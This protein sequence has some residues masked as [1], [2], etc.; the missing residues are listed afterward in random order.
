MRA[1]SSGRSKGAGDWNFTQRAAY[2][3]KWA[4][5]AQHLFLGFDSDVDAQRRLSEI[6]GGVDIDLVREVLPTLGEFE[7][8]YINRGERTM[9]KILAT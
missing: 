6:G 8:L 9:C 7:F 4:Y 3:T 2:I 5:Q 1:T